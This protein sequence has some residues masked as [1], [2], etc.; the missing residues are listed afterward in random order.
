VE[1]QMRIAAEK[2]RKQDEERRRKHEEDA[3]QNRISYRLQAVFQNHELTLP[4]ALPAS[5][6]SYL[7]ISSAYS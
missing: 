4:L 1:E 3:G 5:L 6:F 7:H 2:K